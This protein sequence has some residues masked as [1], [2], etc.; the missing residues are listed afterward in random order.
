MRASKVIDL[1]LRSDFQKW[2]MDISQPLSW[3]DDEFDLDPEP[4]SSAEQ[5][6]R[7]RFIATEYWGAPHFGQGLAWPIADVGIPYEFTID[8]FLIRAYI[9]CLLQQ[10]F[11]TSEKDND[12]NPVVQELDNWRVMTIENQEKIGLGA[13]TTQIVIISS[14]LAISNLRK[15]PI[16]QI[17][18]GIYDSAKGE[19]IESFIG[20]DEKQLNEYLLT[21]LNKES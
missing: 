3:D 14:M 20:L 4:L 21:C 10:V 11:I 1:S 19:Y 17:S 7:D 13:N 15:I 2:I 9:D 6:R 8:K 18:G 5:E 16:R 12:G